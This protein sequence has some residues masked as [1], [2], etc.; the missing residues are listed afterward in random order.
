[1]D[2]QKLRVLTGKCKSSLIGSLQRLGDSAEPPNSEIQLQ[3]TSQ[4][5]FHVGETAELRKWSVRRRPTPN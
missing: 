2:I 5:P 1:M 3:L 4:I